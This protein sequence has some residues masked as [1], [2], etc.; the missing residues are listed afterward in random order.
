MDEVLAD[1]LSRDA[2]RIWHAAGAV[3][4]SWDRS[5]LRALAAEAGAIRA[6]T[7]GVPLGGVLRPNATHLGFA[8]RKMEFAE[9]RPVSA[10]SILPMTC[11]IRCGRRS[12]GMSWW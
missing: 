5:V 10:G 8:L 3:M 9:G 11:S 1:F 2:T 6:A 7:E 4:A 12:G